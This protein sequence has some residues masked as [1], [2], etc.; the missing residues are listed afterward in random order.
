M[1]H[2]PCCEW[3]T[4][5]S[6]CLISFSISRYRPSQRRRYP[7]LRNFHHFSSMF[8]LYEG[9]ILNWLRKTILPHEGSGFVEDCDHE[10][11]IMAVYMRMSLPNSYIQ[12]HGW[13][14]YVCYVSPVEMIGPVLFHTVIFSAMGEISTG[15][16]WNWACFS[17]RSCWNWVIIPGDFDQLRWVIFSLKFVSF[18][19]FYPHNSWNKVVSLYMGWFWHSYY[20]VQLLPT[21]PLSAYL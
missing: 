15:K 19:S 1:G 3:H 21:S 8:I 18:C 16:C 12:F 5:R 4:G 6:F 10:G 13:V 14:S 2:Q 11:S 20:L 17:S 9:D 7:L